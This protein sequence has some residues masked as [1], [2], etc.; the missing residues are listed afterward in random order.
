MGKEK[1]DQ[2]LV[3]ELREKAVLLGMLTRSE[4]ALVLRAEAR[5]DVLEAAER[6]LGGQECRSFWNGSGGLGQR[7]W[8]R[9]GIGN[10]V[11]PVRVLREF[12]Y[13]LYTVVMKTTPTSL[14]EFD[15][16]KYTARFDAKGALVVERQ[17]PQPGGRKVE[18]GFW[19]FSW[20]KDATW[21]CIEC[22]GPSLK[23]GGLEGYSNTLVPETVLSKAKEYLL[24]SIHVIAADS[25]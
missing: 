11:N 9:W 18:R 19:K 13:L 5:A 2:E 4:W 23:A 22:R 1:S 20:Q 14:P 21:K 16:L 10:S 12:A 3:T 17:Q 7:L 6:F 15:R 25:N 24:E 8:S